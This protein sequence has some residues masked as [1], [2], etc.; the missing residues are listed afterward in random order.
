MKD[1]SL[2]DVTAAARPIAISYLARDLKIDSESF[3]SSIGD[4]KSVTLDFSCQIGGPEQT[5]V[6]VFM[7]GWYNTQFNK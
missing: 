5:N 2:C 1:P 7:S 6:G 4:S 3:T